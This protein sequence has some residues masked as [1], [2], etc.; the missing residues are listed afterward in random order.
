MLIL[1]EKVLLKVLLKVLVE[2]LVE[3]IFV[4]FVVLGCFVWFVRVACRLLAVARV[5]SVIIK[6]YKDNQFLVF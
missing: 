1:V 4:V 5:A 3:V 2:V 6:V